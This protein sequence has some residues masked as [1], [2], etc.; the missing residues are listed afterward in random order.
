MVQRVMDRLLSIPNAGYWWPCR[1]LA[2]YGEPMDRDDDRHGPLQTW[3]VAK[4]DGVPP[5]PRIWI[6]KLHN[7]LAQP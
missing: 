5:L 1:Y 2:L 7:T 3:S 4:G 6:T